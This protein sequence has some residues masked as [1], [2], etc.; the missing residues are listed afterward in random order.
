MKR[1]P[2]CRRDYL[3]DTLRFCLD[4][5]S[6]LLEGPSS[7]DT[8]TVSM[9]APDSERGGGLTEATRIFGTDPSDISG[10]VKRR[11]PAAVFIPAA[12]NET[13]RPIWTPDDKGITRVIAEGEKQNLW[14][15]PVDGSPS[16]R[17]TDFEVPGIARRE[18]SRDGK[19]IAIMRAEG[20][21]NAIM[22]TGF[23]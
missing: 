2:E 12:T 23:R 20:I 1:C 21:G 22:I 19:R 3:D 13:R 16:Q 17:M 15:Q 9:R 4:D 14:L 8:P 10:A 5:G 11:I 18:Y 6:E 7:F